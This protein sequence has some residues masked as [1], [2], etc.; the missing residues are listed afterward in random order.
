MGVRSGLYS[1]WRKRE[2]GSDLWGEDLK[3]KVGET[4]DP[5]ERESFAADEE[6]EG[7]E[8]Q[9]EKELGWFLGWIWI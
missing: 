1:G 9:I 6:E 4:K 5:E 8:E 3:V 7:E 2:V